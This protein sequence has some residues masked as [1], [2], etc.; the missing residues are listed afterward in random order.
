MSSPRTTSPQA[1]D[2]SPSAPGTAP[3]SGGTVVHSCTSAGTLLCVALRGEIDYVTVSP[4]RAIMASAAA[5]GFTRL[6]LDT[7]RV[8]FAD[9]A[10]L[11]ALGLWCRDDRRL[12]LAAP[13]RAVQRLL[14]A[15][16]D[17]RGCPAPGL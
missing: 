1:P 16:R 7:S 2:D 8:V 15:V 10:L 6:I 13:S 17:C 12:R 4:L 9:S 3:A 14:E 5:A 11:G